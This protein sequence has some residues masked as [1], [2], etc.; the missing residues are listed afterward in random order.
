M[1][2]TKQN[3][4]AAILTKHGHKVELVKG[5]G[6]FYF[7]A[8]DDTYYRLEPITY[9][10]SPSVWINAFCDTDVAW[11]VCRYEALIEA[12]EVPENA[13]EPVSTAT[14]VILAHKF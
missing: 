11:W 4:A 1:K 12:A 7:T 2:A 9:A 8:A 13:L 10:E 5:N 6:Y 14:I 3:V